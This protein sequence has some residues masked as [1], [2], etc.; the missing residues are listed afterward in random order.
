MVFRRVLELVL[1]FGRIAWSEPE[2]QKFG[3]ITWKTKCG[4]AK[5]MG[6]CKMPLKITALHLSVGRGLDTALAG[7]NQAVVALHVLCHLNQESI[8]V[9]LCH[10]LIIWELAE[11]DDVLDLGGIGLAQAAALL[12]LAKLG[13]VPESPSFRQCQAFFGELLLRKQGILQHLVDVLR[14]LVAGGEIRSV[15]DGVLEVPAHTRQGFLQNLGGVLLHLLVATEDI[16]IHKGSLGTN[17]HGAECEVLGLII[18]IFALHLP[19]LLLLKGCLKSGIAPA[20]KHALDNRFGVG[21]GFVFLKLF[22]VQL[23]VLLKDTTL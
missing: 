22:F 13:G 8:K 15:L 18:G 19:D 20:V 7:L 5:E 21:D 14:D 10:F 9:L 17:L 23:F 12:E 16:L 6:C 2:R 4:P 11:L 1:G 3:T